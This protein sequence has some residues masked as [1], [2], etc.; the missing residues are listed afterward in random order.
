MHCLSARWFGIVLPLLERTLIPQKYR[1]YFPSAMGLGLAWVVPFTNALSF[2]VGAVFVTIWQRLHPK[3]A[4]NFNIP[5]AS[6][7]VAG[8]SL[9]AAVIA[10]TATIIGLVSGR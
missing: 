7:F 6:G 9:V 5:L 10:M 3:S 1:K 2:A 4:D 8:E